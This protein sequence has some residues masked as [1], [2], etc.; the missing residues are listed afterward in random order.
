MP[1]EIPTNL[2]IYRW[3]KKHRIDNLSAII[4]TAKHLAYFGQQI[5]QIAAYQ[6]SLLSF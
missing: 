1:L 6:I 2:A 4:R 5:L 3:K